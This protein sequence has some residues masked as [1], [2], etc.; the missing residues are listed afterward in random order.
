MKKLLLG[1][2]CVDYNEPHLLDHI[3]P[4]ASLLNIPLL[5]A[6]EEMFTLSSLH[7][8]HT[9]RELIENPSPTLLAKRFNALVACKFWPPHLKKMFNHLCNKEM[10][11][12]FCP[13]GQSD[14]GFQEPLLAPYALQDIVLLYGQRQIAMLQELQL[15]D[16][17]QK[18]ARIGNYRLLYYQKY[19]NYCDQ[20]AEQQIFSHLSPNL[21]TLL[22]APTWK[23]AD[24]ATSFFHLGPLLAAAKPSDWNLVVK[25][26]PLLEIRDPAAYYIAVHALEKKPNVLLLSNFPSIYPLLNRCDAYLGD[27]SSVGYDFLFFER[28]MFFFSSP[29]FPQGALHSCGSSIDARTLSLCFSQN[30]QEYARRQ[31]GLY[32][33]AFGEPTTEELLSDAI[34]STLY[35]G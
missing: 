17:I 9:Q 26:H 5:L 11:L 29:H 34:F 14:K 32:L 16:Q 23:D 13:H 21:P 8:P 18:W 10:R 3:A 24:A 25:P 22:Y 15:W 2:F 20:L 33:E 6:D 12:I 31:K 1:A 35:S 7:Y 19:K 27:Y 4:L 30:N 28:P